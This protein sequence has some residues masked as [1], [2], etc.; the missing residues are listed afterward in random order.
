MRFVSRLKSLL[1]PRGARPRR[2]VGGL[3][4]GLTLEL[5]LQTKTQVYL[6]LWERETYPFIRRAAARCRWAVDVGAGQGE[7]ALYLLKHSAAQVVY[8]FEPQR[9]EREAF[10]RNVALNAL[11]DPR[12][13]C[14]RGEFVGGRKE[15]GQ[16]ALDALA[17]PRGERGFLKVDVDG[18]EVDVLRSGDRLLSESVVDVLVETHAPELE[19]GCIE[20]LS[21]KGFRCEVIDPAWW[22]VLVPEERPIPHNRWLWAAEG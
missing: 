20:L 11:P 18:A 9:S 21:G 12:A 2:V 22:R 13:L 7:L 17:L 15:E 6:G 10:A 14:L 1:V 19:A 16:V 5:D 3:Y 4:R 8:A